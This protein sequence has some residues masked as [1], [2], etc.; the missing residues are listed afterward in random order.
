MGTGRDIWLIN[1]FR[2]W[3]LWI[4]DEWSIE[5]GRHVNHWR[6]SNRLRWG[7]SA[8]QDRVRGNVYS[9]VVCFLFNYTVQEYIWL[10]RIIYAIKLSLAVP[11]SWMFFES[12]WRLLCHC[13][14]N[15]RVVSVFSWTSIFVLYEETYKAPESRLCW[16]NPNARLSAKWTSKFASLSTWSWQIGTCKHPVP[17]S[18]YVRKRYLIHFWERNL[19]EP[20]KNVRTRHFRVANAEIGYISSLGS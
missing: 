9:V 1:D 2:A 10:L 17:W 5:K 15:R 16:G 6:T 3:Y 20:H 18:L 7:L 11:T 13:Q 19:T 4:F 14:G 8:R 12:A